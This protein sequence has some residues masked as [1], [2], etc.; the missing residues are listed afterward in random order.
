MQPMVE[1]EQVTLTGGSLLWS[2]AALDLQQADCWLAGLHSEI[3]WQEETLMMFGR[4]VPVPRRVA[5]HGDA[6]ARYRYS[7]VLHQPA[8]WTAQLTAIRQWLEQVSGGGFNSVLA[9]LYRDGNDA[10]GWHADDEPELGRQP[11][12]ASLSLG[13][14]RR[15]RFRRKDRQGDSFQLDLGH[16][17]LLVMDGDTQQYWQHC[18]TRS[19][20]VTEPRVNLT[21]RQIVRD[22]D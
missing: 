19:R 21:F 15:M 3:H 17:S 4:P 11:V 9:N 8:P 10:M 13:A 22:A 6:E 1:F 12:I 7:G 2:P 20:R 14:T 18:I 16:G 5:W